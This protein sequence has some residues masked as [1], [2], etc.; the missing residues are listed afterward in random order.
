MRG[1]HRYFTYML[2]SKAQ[3]TLYVGVTNNLA[4]RLEEHSAG[5]GGAF[6]RQHSMH[7]LVWYEQHSEIEHAIA[8]EKAIKK[9][10][11]LWKIRLLE[12]SNPHWA[13][14]G[15]E[16]GVLKQTSDWPHDGS[17]PSRG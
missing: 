14:L 5:E 6:T 16:V 10:R 11:R 12:R 17:P 15:F 9:W 3:G 7:R 1:E 13:D 4:R 8:R 2:A